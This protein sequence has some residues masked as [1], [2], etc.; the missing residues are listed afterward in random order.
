MTPLLGR[1]SEVDT[2]LA[3]H[4]I[5]DGEVDAVIFDLGASSMQFDTAERGFSLSHDAPLDMRMDGDR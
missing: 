1:F 4:G 5:A 3:Q 2:L